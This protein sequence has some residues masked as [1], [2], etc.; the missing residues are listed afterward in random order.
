MKN[1]VKVCLGLW[2]TIKIRLNKVFESV[3]SYVYL[4]QVSLRSP[5]SFLHVIMEP[6]R[7]E[8][9]SR[10]LLHS[11]VDFLGTFAFFLSLLYR[12]ILNHLVIFWKCNKYKNL[13]MLSECSDSWILHFIWR[14][15]TYTIIQV[16][17]E[18]HTS[19][20][21]CFF[22]LDLMFTM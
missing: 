13:Q 20:E 14:K 15:W 3:V 2:I 7:C 16:F 19:L 11:K 17:W 8:I 6:P 1:L 4:S 10:N 9:D 22:H 12:K 18:A 21:L 5:K